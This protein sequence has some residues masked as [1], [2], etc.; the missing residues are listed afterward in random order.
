MRESE[1][2]KI[3]DA[4]RGLRDAG[5]LSRD[6]QGEASSKREAR[7]SQGAWPHIEI[8]SKNS[9]ASVLVQG[10]TH[11]SKKFQV[12][13]TEACAN[14]EVSR[15]TQHNA[16]ARDFHSG[17][18]KTVMGHHS[19]AEKAQVKALLDQNSC[20]SSWFAL[21]AFG[22][23]AKKANPIVLEAPLLSLSNCLV[24]QQLVLLDHDDVGSQV[25]QDALYGA[26]SSPINS[27]CNKMEPPCLN[28]WR[29]SCTLEGVKATTTLSGFC[30]EPFP[31]CAVRWP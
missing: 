27:D 29:V 5:G 18:S 6:H 17:S 11:S 28:S 3:D 31:P 12:G 21:G 4:P 9:N 15:A 26:P 16:P 20:A 24:V 25:F 7:S 1:I 14:L 19:W 8:A 13:G 2:R 22:C 30:C 10:T 23:L